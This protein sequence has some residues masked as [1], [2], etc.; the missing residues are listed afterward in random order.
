[1]S[2]NFLPGSKALED[3]R[4]A[5]SRHI[6]YT[7]ARDSAHLTPADLVRPLSLAIREI[8][9]EK[10]IETEKRYAQADAK[11]LCYLSM[12]FLMGRSL[13]D[14]LSNLRLEAS[15]RQ[16]LADMAIDLDDVLGSEPDAGLGNGGLGRLAAC[17]LESL[18]SMDM[19]GF[20]YGIDY[21]YGLFKQEI[22]NGYQKEK[23]DRWKLDGTPF[24]IERPH[25]AVAV[26]LYGRLE[27]NP[28]V[29]DF[30][31]NPGFKWVDWKTVIGMPNDMPVAGYGGRTVNYL[32]PFSARSSEDFDIEIFNRG[33]YIRAVEQK[34]GSENISRVLYP[35]DSV[36]SGRELRLVQEYFL[37]ACSLQDI[38]RRYR[39]KHADFE[40]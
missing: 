27:P 30:E 31:G 34:I 10:M 4:E 33:D 32:R 18:A 25:E 8:L 15:C 23:P 40:H 2:A 21:E 5:I 36:M 11:R 14:N 9:I 28:A 6:R 13:G 26:Q 17:F 37:V 22:A 38:V 20:G 19:P 7:L 3:L 24:H 35:S 29:K 16:I 1:M 12:E 39:V